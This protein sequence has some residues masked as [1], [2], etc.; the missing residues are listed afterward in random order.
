MTTES[1]AYDAKGRLTSSSPTTYKIPGIQD[2][3]RV[4]NVALIDNPGNDGGIRRSKASGEPPL[5]LSASVL[6]AVKNALSQRSGSLPGLRCPAIPEEIL[7]RLP[8]PSQG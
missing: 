5:L 8:E 1:L 6:M 4:F 3:P 7:M 2:A